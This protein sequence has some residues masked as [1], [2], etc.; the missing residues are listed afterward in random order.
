MCTPVLVGYTPNKPL[1]S[2][3]SPCAVECQ[4]GGWTEQGCS[5]T[6]GG[7]TQLL[8]RTVI[9]QPEVGPPCGPLTKTATCNIHPCPVECELS[10]WESQG[11]SVTCG[12]GMEKFTRTMVSQA[13]HAMA[14][15]ADHGGPPCG[16]L[17]KEKPCNNQP[18]PVDCKLSEWIST[19]VCSATCG[20]GGMTYRRIVVIQPEHGGKPCG[21]LNKTDPCSTQSC[22]GKL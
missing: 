13:G 7:G 10:K 8:T 21:A 2:H 17:T 19:S 11:C 12:S 1:T 6:C 18:C 14:G 9:S 5:A 22:P 4:L 15:L 20:G 3:L 16:E